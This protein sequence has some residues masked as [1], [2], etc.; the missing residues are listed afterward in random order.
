MQKLL[1]DLRVEF[2]IESQII[3]LEGNYQEHED[4]EDDR[5]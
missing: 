4:V 1:S 2:G 5:A 3:K